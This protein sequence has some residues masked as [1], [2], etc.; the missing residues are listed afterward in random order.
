VDRN[1]ILLR[2]DARQEHAYSTVYH[3]Y[4]HSMLRKASAWMPLWLNE[5]LAQFY[6]NTDMDDKTAWLGEANADELRYLKRNDL[7]PIETLLKVDAKSPYYHDEEKGSVFY[8]ESW[9]LTHYL[10]IN[11]LQ[12]HTS[13]VADYAKYLIARED[14][15]TA[16][17]HAFGDLNKLQEALDHY[18]SQSNFL[19][20]TMK[21]GAREDEASYRLVPIT[22]AGADAYRARVLVQMNRLADA[23]ALLKTTLAED[24]KDAQAHASMGYL[25]M[26][27]GDFDAA[28]QWYGE[29]VALDPADALAAFSFAQMCLRTNDHAHDAEVEADLRN[30]IQTMPRDAQAYDALANF[31]AARREKLTEAHAMS[32]QAVSLDPGNLAY[33]LNAANVLAEDGQMPNAE[34]VLKAARAIAHS[35]ED[36]AMIDERLASMES[37]AAMAER[38]KANREAAMR[39]APAAETPRAGAGGTLQVITVPEDAPPEH[40]Y[41]PG[42]PTGPKRVVSGVIR[43]VSCTYPTVLTLTV[44]AAGKKTALYA[45]NYF[46]L[47]FRT[48]N[49]VPKDAISPCK[50][51]EGMKAKVQ[52]A[53]VT[54]DPTVAGQM[55]AIDL[56]K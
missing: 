1:Y 34:N 38:N 55:V 49:F 40:V 8:A 46:K 5:G 17:Q 24:P 23:E 39:E 33:R 36:T 14:P 2:L 42:P 45:N 44:D 47:Q 20:L 12:H 22:A 32:V 30:V 11:D 19:Q 21:T 18:V 48:L 4:T 31:Y 7:L 29:A 27:Q 26:R 54:S 56:S 41:P 37:Y 51:I 52:Y 15:V 16:A 25:K 35:P 10:E 6:E 13:L 43:D 50:G 9:A 28:K 53:E 3:E